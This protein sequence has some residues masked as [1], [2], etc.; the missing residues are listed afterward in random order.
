MDD[1]IIDAGND[2]KKRSQSERVCSDQEKS[3]IGNRG[4]GTVIDLSEINHS[5]AAGQKAV[6]AFKT[7]LESLAMPSAIREM[8]KMVVQY[9]TLWESSELRSSWIAVSDQFDSIRA[10]LESVAHFPF[11]QDIQKITDQYRNL[12]DSSNLK[13]T[14]L[15]MQK[16]YET[17]HLVLE[18]PAVTK[19]ISD[20]QSIAQGYRKFL[21]SPAYPKI[22]DI[23]KSITGSM[24][25]SAHVRMVDISHINFANVIK[26]YDDIQE[27]PIVIHGDGTISSRSV[28]LTVDDIRGVIDDVVQKHVDLKTA[29][30]EGLVNSL[31][32]RMSELKEPLLKRIFIGVII[33]LI[34]ALIFSFVK[35]QI[36]EATRYLSINRRAMVKEIKKETRTQL[37]ID[38]ISLKDFRFVS[39]KRLNLRVNKS[40]RATIVTSLYLG[41]IVRVIEKRKNWTLVEHVNTETQLSVRGW[42]F[43]RYLEKIR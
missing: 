14:I 39:A 32:L 29:S 33:G 3:H 30:I 2:T 11:I 17:A 24:D 31:I 16:A 20:V 15:E 12:C 27:M 22:D 5:I 6:D 21:D 35:P 10:Q 13:H 25:A 9:K 42:V 28:T 23:I 38:A 43:T 41:S 18:S 34:S 36:D 1:K 26:E 37:T 19:I 40:K 8:Q 7:S 4:R